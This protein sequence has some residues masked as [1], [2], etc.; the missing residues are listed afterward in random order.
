MI[1]EVEV[2]VYQSFTECYISKNTHTAVS[3]KTKQ[4]VIWFAKYKK[5]E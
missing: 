3:L 4:V 5:M 1:I 2:E